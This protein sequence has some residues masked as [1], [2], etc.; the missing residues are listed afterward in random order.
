MM[1]LDLHGGIDSAPITKPTAKPAL[2]SNAWSSC[3]GYRPADMNVYLV[4]G[5]SEL[6]HAVKVCLC[7]ICLKWVFGMGVGVCHVVIM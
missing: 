7:S 1:S 5:E 4:Q 6:L 3:Y 2:H